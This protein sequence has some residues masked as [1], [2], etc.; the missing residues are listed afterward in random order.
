MSPRRAIL[1][2]HERWLDDYLLIAD[3]W[4]MSQG[5][6]KSIDTDD[7]FAHHSIRV[8]F[9]GGGRF[10]II[11]DLE[12]DK[13]HESIAVMDVPIELYRVRRGNDG[14]KMSVLNAFSLASTGY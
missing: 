9:I 5:I 1:R 8:A 6:Q 13:V 12:K 14:S 11:V 3:A 4:L 2:A 7:G 10:H